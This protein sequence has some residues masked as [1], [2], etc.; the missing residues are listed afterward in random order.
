MRDMAPSDSENL[1]PRNVCELPRCERVV[2][3]VDAVPVRIRFD[4]RR[5]VGRACSVAHADELRRGWVTR[6]LYGAD[7]VDVAAVATC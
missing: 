6:D 7:C 4:G 3:D 5:L 2:C 1:E